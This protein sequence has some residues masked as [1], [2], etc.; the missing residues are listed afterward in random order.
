MKRDMKL[1][2]KILH[3]AEALEF[4]DDEPYERYRART[5]NEAY[6]IALMKDAGLVDANLVRRLHER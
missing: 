3:S 4:A 6:Q 5:P 1:I 2:R